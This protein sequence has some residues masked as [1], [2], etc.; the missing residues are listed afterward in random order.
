MLIYGICVSQEAEEDAAGKLVTVKMQNP[1]TAAELDGQEQGAMT[2]EALLMGTLQKMFFPEGPG[3][4]PFEI[5]FLKIKMKKGTE[6]TTTKKK[7]IHFSARNIP[8]KS[9]FFPQF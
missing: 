3:Q 7:P 9:F 5:L 1:G 4:M 2:P 6:T 8:P